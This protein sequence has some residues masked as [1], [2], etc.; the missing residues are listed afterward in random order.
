MALI[1]YITHYITKSDCG[2]YQRIM[3]AV[4]VK[5]AFDN[6]DNNLITN[7]FNYIPTFDKFTLKIFNQLFYN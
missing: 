3:A 1:Y 7:P 5:K 2:Q 4:M 6:H